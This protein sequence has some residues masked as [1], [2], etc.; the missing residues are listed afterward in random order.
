MKENR[1]QWMAAKHLGWQRG[2][3]RREATAKDGNRNRVLLMVQMGLAF[4]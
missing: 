1:L 2:W 4:N 3:A